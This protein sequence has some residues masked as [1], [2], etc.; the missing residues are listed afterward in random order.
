MSDQPTLLIVDGAVAKPL[1]LSFDDLAGL[2]AADRVDDISRFHPNRQGSGVTLEAVL[3]LAEVSPE[4]RYITLHA[5]RDD[6]HVPVPLQAVRAEAVIVFH[7][8]GVPLGPKHGGPIRFIIP[9]PAACHTDE[10]DD[11]ANVKYLSRMEVTT[12]RGRDTRPTTDA[13]HAALHE[14]QG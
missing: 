11:C 6:F 5:D 10:L 9:N 13:E 8:N 4:A 1:R 3:R 2:P 12:G 7:L 14:K